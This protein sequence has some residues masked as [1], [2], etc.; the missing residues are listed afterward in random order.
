MSEVQ[1]HMTCN[2]HVLVHVGGTQMGRNM[3]SCLQFVLASSPFI[4]LS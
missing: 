1:C 3:H 4:N 2:I